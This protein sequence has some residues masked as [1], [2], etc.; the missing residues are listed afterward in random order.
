[1]SEPTTS[2]LTDPSAGASPR[3]GTCTELIWPNR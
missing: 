3:P 1:V 2:R